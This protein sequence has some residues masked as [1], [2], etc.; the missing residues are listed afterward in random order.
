MEDFLEH[1]GI[2]GQKWGVT[3]GPPYPIKKR[4]VNVLRNRSEK[5]KKRGQYTI[6]K[7][8]KIQTLSVDK[9][10]M[11]SGTFFYAAATPKD[12][13]FYKM[14]F[15]EPFSKLSRRPPKYTIT[16]TAAKRMKIANEVEGT[17]AFARL[18]KKSPGF[19]KYIL[20]PDGMDAE[21]DKKRRSYKEYKRALDTLKQVRDGENS[22][23]TNEQFRDLFILYNLTYPATRSSARSRYRNLYTKELE[24]RG[25]DGFLDTNDA[26]YGKFKRDVPV[27][28][29]NTRAIEPLSAVLGF[30]PDTTLDDIKRILERKER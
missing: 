24:A 2:L 28:I 17:K 8:Q 9:N 7:G 13:L 23:P 3:H 27:I 11:K 20:S 12:R 21:V 25:F 14:F 15:S 26:L 30:D 29:T 1:H 16:A 10:R 19:R 18:Y 5:S 4:L 22:S 6:R